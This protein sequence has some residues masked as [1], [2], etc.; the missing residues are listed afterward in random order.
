MERSGT[1][2]R[3]YASSVAAVARHA[4]DSR[5]R[6]LVAESVEMY[7][8]PGDRDSRQLGGLML[9]ELARSAADVFGKHVNQ[10]NAATLL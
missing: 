2:R 1:V 6:K 9:R 10:V 4:P 5:V 7:T 3:S 8:V